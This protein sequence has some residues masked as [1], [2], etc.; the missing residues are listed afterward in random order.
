[1]VLRDN[2]RPDW[3]QRTAESVARNHSAFDPE[4]VA[5]NRE[6]LRRIAADCAARGVRMVLY[7]PPTWPTYYEHLSDEV[8]ALTRQIGTSLAREFP[9]VR[10]VDLLKDRRFTADDFFDASHLN[11]DHGG[12][13]LI[14]ILDDEI[15]EDP[16]PTK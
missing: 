8:V 2:R 10:Y 12:P 14:R 11:Y 6:V 16:F 15:A 3:D 5:H 9:N 1:M 7:T 13:K 4:D